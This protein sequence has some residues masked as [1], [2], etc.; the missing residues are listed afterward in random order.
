MKSRKIL[1]ATLAAALA[2]NTA[3]VCA[4][5]EVPAWEAPTAYNGL[6]FTENNGVYG[7]TVTKELL[8]KTPFSP[9]DDTVGRSFD[10][11]WLGF[12]V[13]S[14][15]KDAYSETTATYKSV[16]RYVANLEADTIKGLFAKASTGSSTDGQ[17]WAG[18]RYDW[19]KGATEANP[20]L[21]YA[22][23]IDLGTEKKYVYAALNCIELGKDFAFNELCNAQHT[24]TACNVCGNAILDS[25][26]AGDTG[27]KVEAEAGV[28]PAG[29]AVHVDDVTDT[30]ASAEDANEVVYDI[31]LKDAAGNVVEPKDGAEI[32]VTVPVPDSMKDAEDIYVYHKSD[33]GK[34]TKLDST[35]TA[36]GIAFTV[37][38]F[39]LYVL[40]AD[41]NLDP[42]ARTITLPGEGGWTEKMVAWA[43]IL[44]E[45]KTKNDVKTITLETT[46]TDTIKFGCNT[47]ESGGW[48]DV[49]DANM[50][51]KLV[52]NMADYTGADGY[53]AD[54]FQ[55]GYKCYTRIQGNIRHYCYNPGKRY[56]NCR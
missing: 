37:D 24:T 51:K 9:K 28:V 14:V 25:T 38:H 4:Y 50:A 31:V 16:N 34:Y 48:K 11:Y 10:G 46:G 26:A 47:S 8:D 42:T 7:A 33:D 12:H 29:T 13:K 39:S 22:V 17:F 32:T 54:E 27:V 44:P 5:A 19:I 52:I 2:V 43:D 6:E 23:E 20:Y 30:E 3:A 49:G 36:A 41:P 53:V 35:K 21:V 18:F 15:D 40:S 55:V 45:G 1:T 56:C